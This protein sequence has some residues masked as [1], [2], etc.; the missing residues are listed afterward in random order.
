PPYRT[1]SCQATPISFGGKN[2]F[3]QE[4]SIL[5]HFCE[6][7]LDHHPSNFFKE[8]NTTVVVMDVDENSENS[9]TDGQNW[10]RMVQKRE[11]NRT[12]MDSLEKA[13]RE[14]R[15]EV[16]QKEMDS[17][18]K[19]YDEVKSQKVDIDL[20]QCS[21]PISIVF[22]LMEESE[23]PLSMLLDEIYEKMKKIKDGD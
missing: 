11:R 17:L 9:S 14:A 23:L 3:S 6:Q 15:I 21:S 16:L 4:Q 22:A 13:E 5:Q 1:P 10:P 7:E 2:Q 19:Y 18:F 12:E 20:D 8:T